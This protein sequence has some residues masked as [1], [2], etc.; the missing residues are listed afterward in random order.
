MSTVDFLF[1]AYQRREIDAA[2]NMGKL[3][4]KTSVL[5]ISIDDYNIIN[6]E[7]GYE[8]GDKLLKDVISLIRKTVRVDDYIVR[9]NHDDFLVVLHHTPLSNAGIVGEKIRNIVEQTEFSIP[10]KHVSVSL[11]ASS[12]ELKETMHNAIEVVEGLLHKT[13][14]KFS[15][16]VMLDYD[17]QKV[18]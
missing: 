7:H 2:K 18:N 1:K 14:S 12:T 11:A 15:N 9:W 6:D 5:L 3:T 13:R 16:E 8:V 10:K 17:N 4:E